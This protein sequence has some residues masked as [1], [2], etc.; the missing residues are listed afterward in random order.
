[1]PHTANLE[2]AEIMP[3]GSKENVWSFVCEHQSLSQSCG[4]TI[5]M[6][7]TQTLMQALLDVIETETN[8]Q[9]P[10]YGLLLL[11]ASLSNAVP[12]SMLVR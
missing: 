12:V 8:E 5:F 3:I 9:S 6:S 1:M 7:F 10:N 2:V 4:L 11:W